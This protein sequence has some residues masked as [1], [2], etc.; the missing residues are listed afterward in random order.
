MKRLLC[1]LLS[2][3]VFTACE[4]DKDTLPYPMNELDGTF[5]IDGK[6]V[7]YF[8][9]KEGEL[10]TQIEPDV[11]P[12]SQDLFFKRNAVLKVDF[13]L[14]CDEY[15]YSFL[16]KDRKMII[17]NSVYDLVEYNDSYFVIESKYSYP[18]SQVPG[19]SSHSR[20]M[21][22]HRSEPKYSWEDYIKYYGHYEKHY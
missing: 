14:G 18:S 6:Y 1:I 15:L 4:D 19:S 12:E 9:D 10:I 2:F 11:Y 21:W 16:W 13:F 3:A 17:G 5:W 8:Y 22:Y 7:D 20:R